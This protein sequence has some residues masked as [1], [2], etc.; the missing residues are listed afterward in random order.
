MEFIKS[1]LVPVPAGEDHLCQPSFSNGK[2]EVSIFN[3]SKHFN[4]LTARDARD[5]RDASGRFS[6]ISR[7]PNHYMSRIGD[8]A[9]PS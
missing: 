7:I 2:P 3:V 4:I 6:V 8:L 1:C 5:A 9:D